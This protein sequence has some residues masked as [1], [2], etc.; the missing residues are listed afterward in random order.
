MLPSV[1]SSHYSQEH[2]F[3]ADC[4]ILNIVL[5]QLLKGVLENTLTGSLVILYYM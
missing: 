2:D 5:S 1:L 3:P 4:T